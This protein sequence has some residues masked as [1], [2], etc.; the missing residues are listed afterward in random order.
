MH[1]VVWWV[2]GTKPRLQNAETG[3]K[4]TA[5]DGYRASGQR[6]IVEFTTDMNDRRG[7]RGFGGFGGGGIRDFGAND[8]WGFGAGDAIGGFGGDFGSRYSSG[9][10][11]RR[12]ERKPVG[13]P[14][15]LTGLTFEEIRDQCLKDGQLF[16]DP[17]FGAVDSNIFYSRSP[18]RPFVW[19]RPKVYEPCF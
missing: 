9:W 11:T 12:D 16:E 14:R 15:K 6:T 17:D 18:P 3:A 8:D 2:P 7:F 4:T 1:R 13:P 10:G 5:T 19:K